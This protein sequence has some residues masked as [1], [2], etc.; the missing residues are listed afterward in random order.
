MRRFSYIKQITVFVISFFLV[1]SYQGYA[2]DASSA[3]SAD[4]FKQGIFWSIAE[5]DE[6]VGYLF[7]TF[8]SNDERVL[9]I[10]KNVVRAL[11]SSQSFSMES[12]PGSR[13][14]NP[15]WGFRSIIRDMT[16]PNSQSL[17]SLIGEPL[18]KEVVNILAGIGVKEERIRNLYPW[19]VMNELSARK[20]IS[21]SKPSGK[22]LDHQ[23]FEMAQNKELYQVENL[24]ELMA[25]YDD[26]PMDAQIG[27]L[28]D[29]VSSRSSLPMISEQMVTSYLDEDLEKLLSLSTQ[30]ISD[31]SL[32]K[33]YDKIYLKNVLYERNYV[34][35]HH[36]LAPLRRKGAFISIGALH[37]SGGAG[38]LSQLEGYG[39]TV[40]R[41]AL[42]S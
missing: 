14:F 41:V 25:A 39:Y 36:M 12:F 19:A 34:M 16:L 13:Y 8:H 31:D 22:I 24:E 27:L 17:A 9:R 40:T 10:S 29:R 35:A 4:R 37:L 20:I 7:G 3:K 15:H 6:I 5:D 33:G 26:F 18:Y 30:F 38:V 2:D 1:A 32:A 21:Q 42:G 28:K 23:L 11:Q